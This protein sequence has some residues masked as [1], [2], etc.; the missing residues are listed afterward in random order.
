MTEREFEQRLRGFYRSEV[1]A[2]AHR[3][4]PDL[5]ERVWAIPDA[6]AIGRR[7][8]LASRRM[9]L[10]LAA[11]MLL[12]LAV[13]TAIAVGAGLIPW[14]EDDQR[15]ELSVPESWARLPLTDIPAGRYYVDVASAAGLPPSSTIRVTFTLP[16]G[17]E[18]VQ[19]QGYL[20]GQT[21]WIGMGVID[22]FYVDPCHPHRGTRDLPAD[23][24]P[25]DVAASLA[26][27][28]EWKVTSTTPA[29]LA[30]YQGVRVDITAPADASDCVN[31]EPRLLRI[32]GLYNYIPASRE[33][34][35]M[36]V[37]IL[38]VEGLLVVIV[39]G[40]DP[41]D[42]TDADQA[43]LRHVIDSIEIDPSAS[44]LPPPTF[45]P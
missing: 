45:A 23:S 22:R 4:P 18:R 30:G 28:P 25:D 21:K 12:A 9:V 39:G 19:V 42:A 26:S 24:T 13:G 3:I 7:G 27:L 35:P 6:V 40:H 36:R 31:Q 44:G 5:R 15:T 41:V 8:S 1:E 37:W 2:A 10:L 43:E 14:L 32:F 29:A 11:A 20:W 16:S 17:W 38:D 33:R 34:E